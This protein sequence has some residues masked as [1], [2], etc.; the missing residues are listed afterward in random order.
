MIGFEHAWAFVLA[1][2]WTLLVVAVF[3]QQREALEW[4]RARMAEKAFARITVYARIRP[5]WHFLWLWA[6]GALLIAAATGPY[7]E[8]L[9]PVK[10]ESR[11]IVL[12][13][14]VSLSML[15]P[16]VP[17]D[18]VTGKKHDNR[19]EAAKAFG[20]ELM[21]A[22]PDSRFALLSFAGNA[23]VHSPIT[24]DRHA[25]R[26]QLKALRSYRSTQLTGSEFGQALGTVVHLWRHREHPL[27]VVLLSDGDVSSEPEPFDAQLDALE[28]LQ[29]PVHTVVF[30]GDEDI[31]MEVYDPEDIAAETAKPRVMASFS[32]R[33]N[34]E[35]LSRIS[36][37][38]DGEALR[39]DESWV[40]D[41]LP[42]V[43][44]VPARAVSL[45]HP[46][47]RDWSWLLVSLFAGL[48]IAES[49]VFRRKLPVVAALLLSV[50]WMGCSSDELSA[51]RLNE[52]GR[53]RFKEEDWKAAGAAF[54]QSSAFQVRPWVPTHN[55]AMAHERRGLYAES[56]RLMEQAIVMDPDFVEGFFGDGAVLYQWGQ[57]EFHLE[58]CRAERTR[59]LWTRSRERFAQAEARSGSWGD[60]GARAATNRSFLEQRL[61]WL[62]QEEERCANTPDAGADGGV[63]D[64]GEDGGVDGGAPDAGEDGGADAGSDGGSDGG[65]DGGGDAGSDGGSDGGRDA[66][67]DAGDEEGSGEEEPGDGGEG[68]EP[69]GGDPEDGPDGGVPSGGLT[70]E[71]RARVAAEL[72]RARKAS[73]EKLD[74]WHQVRG[75][76]L[77][78]GERKDGGGGNPVKW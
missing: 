63:P 62:S 14:D 77:R 61:E 7:T 35:T 56:H 45:T 26:T 5:R 27:Q 31:S 41:L 37:R 52:E 40:K 73:D 53:E 72:E 28:N 39:S 69:D 38:T 2:P 58:N 10:R 16:D 25:V 9:G 43:E 76:Q 23:S 32:T 48:F 60:V 46:S 11:D 59:E 74:S 54:E 75:S 42:A 50:Q 34:E 4:L 70:E 71:E 67:S 3:G 78:L 30:G 20:A 1:L 29:I 15:A 47:R 24:V 12:I 33:R 49:R 65:A 17:P 66:G 68:D 22:L 51:H 13:V 36:Q 18:P 55:L 6:M 21:D 57:A 64:A 8:S 19:L 44:S